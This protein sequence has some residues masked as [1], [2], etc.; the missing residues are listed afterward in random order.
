MLGANLQRTSWTPEEATGRLNLEWYRPIEAYIPQ[1]VQI[2]AAN[3]LLYVSTS[4]GLY[5]LNAASGDVAWRFDTAMPLGNSPTVID[6]VAYV[7][8]YDRKLHALNAVTGAHLWSYDGAKAG[9]SANPLVVDGKVIVGNRDGRLYAIGAHGTP[10]QGKIVW[11]FNANS[12]IRLSAAYADGVI[13]FAAA[14]N[15]AYALDS[16]DGSLLWKSARL[17]GEQYQSYWPVI[18]R[19]KVIYSGSSGYRQIS[20]PGHAEISDGVWTGILRDMQLHDIFP[21][22]SEGTTIGPAVPDQAWAHGYPIIDASRVTEYLEDNPSLDPDVHKPWRRTYVVLNQSD[23]SEYTF[24]SDGDSHPEYLPAAWWGTNSGN[25]FPPLVGPDNTLYFN[26]LYTCCSDEKGR[27]MGWTPD[28]PSLLSVTGGFGALAEPQAISAGGNYI[29][30]NLCCDRVG[31]FFN[32][33]QPSASGRLWSYDLETKAPGYDSM[34]RIIPGLPRLVGWYKGK[35]AGA[36]A[37]YHNHGDQNPII[38]YQ[39]RAYVHR[40]NAIIAFGPGAA[41]GALPLLEAQP[42]APDNAALPRNAVVAELESEIDKIIDAGDLRPGYYGLSITT[43]RGFENAFDN[44]GDTLYT[45]ARAYPYLSSGLQSEVRTYMQQQFAMHFDP[46]MHARLGWGAGAP[47]ESITLPPEVVA[48]L[49]NFPPSTR[50]PYFAWEYPQHNFYAMWKY[51]EIVPD[52][53]VPRLRT[54]E[55]ET[56]GA[57]A[58]QPPHPGLFRSA[59][60]RVERLYRRLRWIP[61]TPGTGWHGRN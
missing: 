48:D 27:V 31:D 24:D 22:Q 36:N 29:Y 21:S 59:P 11:Q 37:A 42:P 61:G 46:N 16:N 8:G 44:P 35:T 47:R 23:G 9:Y 18:Y 56:P 19:D 49:G 3:G 51:A 12:P 10:Q 58:H 57:V 39:G 55:I 25:R 5:A 52:D 33:M 26:N 38:P 13:H 2:I 4:G 53:A 41:S 6:G 15:F 60:V 17:P 45:M 40:S 30:R 34:W 54:C 32:M 14:N 20:R 50:S 7:G 28:N 43:V 1:N